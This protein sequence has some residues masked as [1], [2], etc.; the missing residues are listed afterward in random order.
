[1]LVVFT[2]LLA[3]CGWSEHGQNAPLGNQ[4]PLGTQPARQVEVEAADEEALVGAWRVVEATA[5][6]E[7]FPDAV[8]QVYVF[9]KGGKLQI[10]GHD[11][12]AIFEFRM[13]SYALPKRL[14]SYL[15]DP[16]LAGSGIYELT[17]DDLKWRTSDSE[18]DLQFS[19]TPSGRWNEKRMVRLPEKEAE[20][21]IKRLKDE[22]LGIKASSP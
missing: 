21:A 14:V 7:R 22:R 12:E 1:M 2:A 6:G 13:D 18:Q 4:A 8:G 11:Y 17:K 19:A 5:D 20:A 10:Y 9:E 16:A 3:G 15:S